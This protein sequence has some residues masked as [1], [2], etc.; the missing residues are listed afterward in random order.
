MRYVLRNTLLVEQRNING[1][2]IGG[3]RCAASIRG[4]ST[5]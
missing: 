2:I 4:Q 1:E 5:P 3:R